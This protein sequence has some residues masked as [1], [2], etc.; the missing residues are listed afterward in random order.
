MKSTETALLL[1]GKTENEHTTHV[2]GVLNR[3][4]NE[5]A[6]KRLATI[7]ELAKRAEQ[8]QQERRV[9]RNRLLLLTGLGRSSATI[10][11]E[12][13]QVLAQVNKLLRRYRVS[14]ALH[15]N[16]DGGLDR[17]LMPSRTVRRW[18]TEAVSWITDLARNRALS[19]LRQ[20]R[21]CTKWIY[22]AKSHRFYCNESCRKKFASTAGDF[23]RKRR[24]YMASYRAGLKQRAERQIAVV[25]GKKR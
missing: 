18:E 5:P 19:R 10:D 21:H 3:W 25:R 15:P 12:L 13:N 2:L 14:L 11:Q 17:L 4:P 16:A 23:K 7:L 20:C 24:E 1:L 8:L 6:L 22:A 9:G